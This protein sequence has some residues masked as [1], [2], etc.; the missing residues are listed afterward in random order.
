VFR[1]RT[2]LAIVV[3]AAGVIVIGLVLATRDTEQDSA[4]R[5]ALPTEGRGAE[6]NGRGS[7]DAFVDSIGVGSH[8]NYVDTAYARRRDVLKAL[9]E[10]G[11]HH[12]REGVPTVS[13]HTAA[14]LREAARQG[15]RLTVGG[16]LETNPDEGVASALREV[17][18]QVEAFEAPNELDNFGPPDWKAKLDAYLPALRKAMRRH[19]AD[20]PLIGPS[21][22]NPLNYRSVE[23]SSYDLAN[24]HPYSGGGPPEEAVERE[25]G[26]SRALAPGRGQVFTE[27][28][29]HNAM[30]ATEGQP[31][32]P[33]WAAA[34]YLPRTFLSSFAAGVERTFVYELVD[35]KPDPAL[36]N[37]EQHFGLL[38]HDFS[39]KLAFLAVRNLIRSVRRSPG[40]SRGAPPPSVDSETEIERVVLT[41]RDGSRVV[42]V[43]RPVSVWD[44]GR[45]RPVD[46]GESTVDLS[47][48]TPVRDL[49]VTYPSRSDKPTQ[50]RRSASRSRLRVASDVV[51]LSYR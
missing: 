45:R 17:G 36:T 47:W 44:Q 30:A 14:G 5:E 27:T 15:V 25:L 23:R 9:R 42:A 51:L 3:L 50:R 40:P 38:R 29:Y 7:A 37:P 20:V 46:P 33:E 32:V 26:H 28:G 18:P 43:W 1:T 39:P 35:E 49:T 41:R 8:F 2:L 34:I 6:P 24:F 31:P 21:F 12:L 13:P 19:G 48:R 4:E 10:L 11:V 22:V 16:G